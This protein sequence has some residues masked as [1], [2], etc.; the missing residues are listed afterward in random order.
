[1]KSSLIALALVIGTPMAFVA[2]AAAQ[3]AAGPATPAQQ[4]AA[5]VFI[6]KLTADAFAILAKSKIPMPSKASRISVTSTSTSTS[7]V[8]FIGS[9]PK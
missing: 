5:A 8:R 1:L 2:P 3:E 6:D 7:I 4:K 9:P